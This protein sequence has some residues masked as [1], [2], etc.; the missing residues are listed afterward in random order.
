MVGSLLSLLC[1]GGLWSLV[2]GTGQRSIGSPLA[3]QSE[4]LL[5]VLVTHSLCGPKIKNPFRQAVFTFTEERG[6]IVYACVYVFVC[7]CVCVCVCMCV[8][9]A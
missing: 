1:L 7:L 8:C 6:L 5:V 2:P 3:D 9:V 4:L